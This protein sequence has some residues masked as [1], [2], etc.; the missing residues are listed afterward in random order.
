MSEWFGLGGVV[1][2]IYFY[3]FGSLEE[4][5]GE[6]SPFIY[7]RTIYIHTKYGIIS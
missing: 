3:I 4:E 7:T 6:R 5:R 1:C 2:I